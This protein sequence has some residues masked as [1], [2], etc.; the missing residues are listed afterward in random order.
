M[1]KVLKTIYF[2][3]ILWFWSFM[4]RYFKKEDEKYSV[5]FWIVI[6]FLHC[7]S[8]NSWY[9][10]TCVL[11]SYLSLIAHFFPFLKIR[12]H[13]LVKWTDQVVLTVLSVVC[14]P[15]LYCDHNWSGGN[16]LKHLECMLLLSSRTEVNVPRF[17]LPVMGLN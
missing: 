7:M 15:S 13:C 8:G 4:L 3:F 1:I 14:K 16:C 11:F 2:Y 12:E 10:G 17:V 6:V 9:W 5:Q